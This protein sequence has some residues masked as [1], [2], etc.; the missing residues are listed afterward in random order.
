MPGTSRRSHYRQPAPTWR[1]LPWLANPGNRAMST[2]TEGE[3][4]NRH[5]E[6][7][8]ERRRKGREDAWKGTHIQYNFHCKRYH[9]EGCQHM[10]QSRNTSSPS[11]FMHISIYIWLLGERRCS[12]LSTKSEVIE[13]IPQNGSSITSLNCSHMGTRRQKES[14]STRILVQ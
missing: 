12:L 11:W 3:T 13:S 1:L 6:L 5:T 10:S 9:C 8:V 2:H 14:G 7:T 4:G